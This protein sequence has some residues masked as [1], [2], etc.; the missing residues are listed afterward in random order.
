MPVPER[1]LVEQ[2][3]RLAGKRARP[4]H[5]LQGIGDDCAVLQ[6]GQGYD[7]LVTTDFCLEGLHFRRD[8]H[9]AESAGHRCVARGLSD[10]AAMGGDPVAV[11][12][13]L[14]L[15]RKLPQGW[16]RGFMRGLI[17]L[18]E[19]HGASLAGGDTAQSPGGVL[20]DIVVVGRVA[21][22]GAIL[23]SGARTG[24]GLYVSGE[25]G[26]AAAALAEMERSPKK[27]LNPREYTRHFFPE[28]RLT[29][30]R[31]LRE[32]KLASAMI[33]LS[34][35]L[36]TDLGHI[37]EESGVGAEINAKSIPRARVGKSKSVVDLEVALH[38]GEDYELL[39]T[40]PRGRRVP[41]RIG[42][43]GL[44]CIGRI[45]GAR[46]VFVCDGQGQR[47]R[48]KSGGWEHFRS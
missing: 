14:A 9:S 20:A 35:G 8:W 38:G 11:F 4:A 44:T 2:I 39:F 47:R 26:G 29:V 30:G 16:V 27:R 24:D 42:G 23:R 15:P 6:V 40:V 7:S 36:S 18:T 37:C 13:S 48:L 19:E 46:G 34:D 41:A 32:K 10:I 1:K 33:D 25:L 45:V 21:K 22:G 3:R 5:V 28:P 43:V 17:G 31:V 12:L